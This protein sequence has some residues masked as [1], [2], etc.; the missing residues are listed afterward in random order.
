MRWVM[1]PASPEATLE[2]RMRSR[3]DVLPWS[4]WPRTAT[5]GGRATSVAGSAEERSRR[6]WRR[7]AAT[8]AVVAAGAGASSDSAS[9][10]KLSAARTAVSKSI[11]WATVARTPF[12]IR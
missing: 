12:F 3:I 1:P 11:D 4:T 6:G 7:R 2:A 10:P 5:T 8:G 9:K